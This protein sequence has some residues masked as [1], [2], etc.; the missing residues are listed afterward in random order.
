M[1]RT[2]LFLLLIL[3]VFCFSGLSHAQL[4]SGV[5][6][7]SRAV[8]WSGPGVAGGFPVRTTICQTF[9]PGATAAQ[10]S[11]ALSSAACQNK[12]VFLN[13]GT[14]NLAAGIDFGAGTSNVTLRGAGANQTF[15]IFTGDTPCHGNR[16][17]ICISGVS[18]NWGGGPANTGS[19][20]ASSYGPGQTTVTMSSVA[21]MVIG[22]PLILD[23]CN[24]GYTGATC[25]G[26]PVDT[27]NIYVC[28]DSTGTGNNKCNDDNLGTG[29]PSGGQ[30]PRR[31]Q[32]QV[33][34][35]TAINSTTGQVTFTPGLY[36]PNWRAAQSP[37]AWWATGPVSGD[38]IEDL[39]LDHSASTS[40]G[41]T[42]L[43]SV[44]C[45]VKGIRSINAAREHV[46]VVQ[47]ARVT[48]RDSYFFGSQGSGSQSYG[49]EM[50]PSANTLVENNIF[51]RVDT[52]MM[53][54]G[55]CSGCVFGYNFSI[56][57]FYTAP[58]TWMLQGVSVHAAG[59]DNVLFEGNV[60]SGVWSDLFHGTH[61]FLTFFR[62]RFNGW[63][64]GKTDHMIPVAL[65]P[66]SRYYNV[67]GNVL[68]QSGVH[69]CYESTCSTPIYVIGS[70][71]VNVVTGGDPVVGA[72]LMRWG[73]YDTFNNAVRWVAAEVP[74]GIKPYAN[75]V[76]A[77]QS[78]PPSFY[79]PVRP[80]W[81]PST[82][83][84]PPIGPDVALG[85][86]ANVAGHANTNPAQDCYI[87]MGGSANG[88]ETLPLSFSSSGCYSSGTPVVRPIAPGGLVTTP[89]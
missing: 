49:V 64:T 2:N 68:G 38:G 57:D 83:P 41:I 52:P 1:R 11:A 70:G 84:W 44:G 61:H 22:G 54:N 13:A 51:H 37:G 50:F 6:A 65:W 66:F 74:S 67:V 58:S 24:D 15:L 3:L 78:L 14:Y 4:W 28:S 69:A 5:I 86:I 33:V 43:D 73:N 47:S 46:W 89:K 42:I 79:Q 80:G 87:S 30:R 72:T 19:W 21:N 56:N 81:W 63:E 25:T 53:V 27:G 32:E 75:P 62:N 17:D 29:G 55:A 36:M 7:P 76:P 77:N 34:T 18:S 12:V 40:A 85:N 39:S 59:I 88:T 10:I 20:T 31:D 82:K 9:S 8:D 26:V 60:G 45:W 23:Q 71:T 35:I 48:I 16:G